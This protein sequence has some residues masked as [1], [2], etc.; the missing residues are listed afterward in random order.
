MHFAV[1]GQYL[2]TLRANTGSNLE[3]EAAL[4]SFHT[5]KLARRKSMGAPIKRE[6]I[7]QL[8][9]EL[10][11]NR[12]KPKRPGQPDCP[13]CQG[14]GIDRYS[15]NFASVP[16][17]TRSKHPQGYSSSL[18]EEHVPDVD[19][20]ITRLYLGGFLDLPE[21]PDGLFKIEPVKEWPSLN[22][23][24][25]LEAHAT[26]LVFGANNGLD[27]WKLIFYGLCPCGLWPECT[28]TW[29]EQY[30]WIEIDQLLNC[31]RFDSIW[32]AVDASI[33]KSAGKMWEKTS[34][35]DPKLISR[36]ARKHLDD[37]RGCDIR[38]HIQE[39]VFNQ[40]MMVSNF[41]EALF[42]RN[43]ALAITSPEEEANEAIARHRG[44][45]PN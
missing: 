16:A 41:H 40:R 31:S 3:W 11:D 17:V 45:R 36:K 4:L 19:K 34:L 26:Q 35:R 39:Q 1:R 6:R 20:R 25:I 32:E 12:G 5:E 37:C 28:S 38:F 21:A 22:G 7:R 43:I 13:N 10:E 2:S 9:V 24:V 27:Y 42:L 33:K 18:K 23:P 8:V 15:E 29:V 30:D 14:Q 44:E